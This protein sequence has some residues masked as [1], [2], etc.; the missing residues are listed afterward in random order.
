ML[1]PSEV[2]WRFVNQDLHFSMS[3]TPDQK[4]QFRT[5][6]HALNPVLTVAAKGLTE[7]VLLEADRALEDHEL[8]KVKFALGDRTIKQQ[9]IQ[10]LCQTLEATL[11]QQIGN[12]A[13][14]Y[15][16]ATG[17]QPKHSNLLHR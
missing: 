3:L 6:G 11:V 14:I 7:N 15:R 16:G 2:E 10:E 1:R 17:P 13:L 4:K 8:I 9:L 5:I 12:I